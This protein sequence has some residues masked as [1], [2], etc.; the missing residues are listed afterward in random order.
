M[1]VE[2]REEEYY[3]FPP[4]TRLIR[5]NVAPAHDVQFSLLLVGEGGRLRILH[6]AP[7][8]GD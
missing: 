5:I 8:F 7:C 3:G 1:Y 6:A 2:T 4:G